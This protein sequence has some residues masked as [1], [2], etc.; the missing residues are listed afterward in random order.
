MLHQ[1]AYQGQLHKDKTDTDRFEIRQKMKKHAI[2]LES[3]D[4][5]PVPDISFGSCPC[6]PGVAQ[7]GDWTFS[8]SSEETDI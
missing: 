1:F 8:Y 2:R 6:I 3:A 5:Q 7:L 4:G